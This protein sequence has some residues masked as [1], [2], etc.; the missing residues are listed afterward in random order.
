M[1]AFINTFLSYVLVVIVFMA[2]IVIAV[3]LGKRLRDMK[4][5]KKADSADKENNVGDTV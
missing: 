1:I 4:D 3:N 5:Q 2:A